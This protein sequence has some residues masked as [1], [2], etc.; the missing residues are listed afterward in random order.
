MV[1]FTFYSQSHYNLTQMQKNYTLHW[2]D[3]GGKNG[4]KEACT[5]TIKV[6]FYKPKLLFLLTY[7]EMASLL[8][9][10]LHQL[11]QKMILSTLKYGKMNKQKIMIE[12]E[13]SHHSSNL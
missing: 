7:Q 11:Q 6:H 10:R 12:K 5:Y 9:L 13:M 2:Y 4:D 8:L 1:Q 3:A